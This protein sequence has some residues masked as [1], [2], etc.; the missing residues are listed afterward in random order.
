MSPDRSNKKGNEEVPNK[1]V[2][3]GIEFDDEEEKCDTEEDET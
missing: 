1:K 3:T 2:E